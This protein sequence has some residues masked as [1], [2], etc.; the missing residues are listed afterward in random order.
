MEFGP[1]AL[2]SRSIL[3]DARDPAM[4][5]TINT[6]VKFREGFRLFA[7]IVLA[8]HAHEYFELEPGQESPYMLLTSPVRADKRLELSPEPRDSAD[9]NRLQQKRSV[10][11]AVIHVDY[12]ARVQ[13]VDPH[14]HG[15]L[16][17]LLERF[18]AQTDC[19]VLVNTSFNLDWDP[20]VCTP[21]DSYRMF[22]A[23][24]IDLLAMGH[25]VLRKAEQ[26][27]TVTAVHDGT[28][29]DVF[30]GKLASPCVTGGTAGLIRRDDRLICAKTGYEFAV[31][32]NIPQLFWPHEQHDDGR[33][34]TE[35]V[36]AFY[37]RT[38]FPNYDDH[39]S[40]RFLIEK[41]R[42]GRY[43]HRSG[44]DDPYD[45][46]VLEVGCGTGQLTN[47]LGISCRWVIGA[48]MCLNSLRL[49]EA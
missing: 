23:C 19:P 40:V 9:T 29:D 25:Y 21:Q 42:G 31:T 22:M 38:P 48:D 11:P 10:I 16:H 43:T 45:A 44:R 27:A 1:R 37:E 4:Q 3:G 14:R 12:S 33:N 41:F 47:F 28:T 20:I 35:I 46:A 26:P 32:D 36:K 30:E 24:D 17:K 13:P 39:D 49:G 7:P 34:L 5:K 2:G 15:L 18:H 8:E 6:K